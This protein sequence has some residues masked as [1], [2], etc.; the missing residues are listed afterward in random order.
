VLGQDAPD[1]DRIREGLAAI[2]GKSERNDF[3]RRLFDALLI[4]SK[5]NVSKEPYEKLIF[6]MVAV[7]S[8]LL[9]TASEPIQ[10]NIAERMAFLLGESLADRIEIY[11]LVKVVYD[12]RS[13]F[14]HHGQQPTDMETLA[15]FMKRVYVMFFQLILNRSQF[16][17]KDALIEMLW[18]RKFQ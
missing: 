7:E 8:M 17:T 15:Q 18:Q 16:E 10:D 14:L 9:R 4:Y 3:E 1:G 5:N 11:K 13:R 12:I 2:F 6:C